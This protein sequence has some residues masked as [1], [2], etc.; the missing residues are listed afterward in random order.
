MLILS[1]QGCGHL[2]EPTQRKWNGPFRR[3]RKGSLKRKPKDCSNEDLNERVEKREGTLHGNFKDVK[4]KLGGLPAGKP[5]RTLGR[6]FQIVS[7]NPVSKAQSGNRLNVFS[8]RLHTVRL[9]MISQ[10]RAMA[11]PTFLDFPNGTLPSFHD[12]IKCAR[13]PHV[14]HNVA[15]SS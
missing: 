9:N 1:L 10:T 6:R 8:L 5:D 3:N 12:N 15:S 7:K 11:F 2:K 4:G 14:R 13:I